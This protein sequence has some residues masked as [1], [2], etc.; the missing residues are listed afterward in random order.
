MRLVRFRHKGLRQRYN[1]DDAK[2]IL[3]ASANNQVGA[4]LAGA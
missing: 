4:L 3:P 1:D 2:G